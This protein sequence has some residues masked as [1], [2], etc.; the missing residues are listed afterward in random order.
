M[1]LKR[2]K[3][4]LPVLEQFQVEYGFAENQIRNIFPY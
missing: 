1:N 3:D 2:S 4:G